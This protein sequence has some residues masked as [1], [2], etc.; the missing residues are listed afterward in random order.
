MHI[1]LDANACAQTPKRQLTVAT[2]VERSLGT[3]RQTSTRGTLSNDAF[4]MH[5][6]DRGVRGIR[7]LPFARDLANREEF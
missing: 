2:R 1:C 3:G 4:V 5:R 6:R 7:P